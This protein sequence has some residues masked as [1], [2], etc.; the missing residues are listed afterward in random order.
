MK[1]FNIKEITKVP[2]GDVRIGELFISDD[3]IYLK[4]LEFRE[5]DDEC[6]TPINAM[7]LD[8]M[9]SGHFTDWMEVLYLEV[10]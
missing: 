8:G 6:G 9:S 7:R 4:V 5:A 3:E 2:F 1:T 10:E